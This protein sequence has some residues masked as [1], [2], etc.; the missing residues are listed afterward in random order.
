MSALVLC[1]LKLHGK[2]ALFVNTRVHP[3]YQEKMI[4]KMFNLK[5]KKRNNYRDVVM[6]VLS[7]MREFYLPTF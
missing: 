4:E 1:L 6:R 5:K 3:L 2:R 7:M